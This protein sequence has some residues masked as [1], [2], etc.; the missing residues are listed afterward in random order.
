MA[1]I[2]AA[3]LYVPGNAAQLALDPVEHGSAEYPR[4]SRV[5]KFDAYNLGWQI[6]DKERSAQW[7]GE[8]LVQLWRQHQFD[9]IGI[10]EVFEVDYHPGKLGEVNARRQEI[11]LEVLG[12]LNADASGGWLGQQDN[13]C[14]YV[15]Q[16]SLKLVFADHISLGVESQ[17][18]RKSQY[19]RFHPEDA[20]WPLHLYHAHCPSPGKKN[21][22]SRIE[23]SMHLLA[24]RLSKLSANTPRNSTPYNNRT[25]L[26][27]PTF[28]QCLS[29]EI[30]IC[31]RSNGDPFSV[32]TFLNML[33]KKSRLCK[34][35]C[36][37]VPSMEISR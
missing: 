16:R 19:F 25:V 11:L 34:A 10:S 22:G 23:G 20:E 35:Q 29:Q 36:L 30:G 4:M 9:G 24:K 17:P 37:A 32:A 21:K 27:N 3:P 8:E 33:P 5:Y 7:L 14:M 13:H 18:W 2:L 26:N 28:Q 6:T 31:R 15:W 1:G 12:R